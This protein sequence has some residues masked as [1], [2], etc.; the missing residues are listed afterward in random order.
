M[1]LD[2]TYFSLIAPNEEP[3]KAN[4]LSIER[5]VNPDSMNIKR[6]NGINEL[7]VI[8]AQEQFP[9]VTTKSI[10]LAGPTPR[11]KSVKSWRP[12]A[13]D[14]LRSIG[15][16]GIIYVPEPRDG[17]WEKDY[18]KQVEW[19]H[20]AMNICDTIVF[21][22][23]RDLSLD[24][25]NY[26]KM[27]ALTT[28]IEFGLYNNSNKLVVGIPDDKINVS[29]NKY[30]CH[31]CQKKSIP[32]FSSLEDMLYYVNNNLSHVLRK[33]TECCIPAYL[34]NN[35]EFQNWY[36]MQMKNGNILL[37]LNINYSF[38]MPKARK[39]F[40]WIASTIMYIKDENRIKSN[41]FILSRTNLS[42]VVLIKRGNT[43][44]DT[45]IVLVKEYRTPCCNEEAFVYELPGGSSLNNDALQT[46]IEEIKE[47][48][49]ISLDLLKLDLIESR[50]SIA[51]LS[52]HKLI[53]YKYELSTDEFKKLK[54]IEGSQHGLEADSE[55]TYVIIKS[56]DEIIN[57]SLL[58]WTNIGIILSAW[59]NK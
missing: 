1:S 34:W 37:D 23:P 17:K 13:I 3:L 24:K 59:S 41:E 45:Y 6:L 44:K 7:D 57:N 5:L 43:Y 19:E 50:Q 10:F 9:I 15:Y 36:T 33:E 49:G 4:I 58:D 26:P 38:I 11:D 40:L 28:N 8:Y 14:Y 29:S 32:F 42:S 47:E 54:K 25:N 27:A 51:T 55:R 53:A 12:I 16:D 2:N 39:L 56:L 21:W 48:V 30:I 18:D 35:N 20:R 31:I 46:A 52:A 22:I